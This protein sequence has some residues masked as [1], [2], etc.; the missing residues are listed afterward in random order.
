[1]Q[2]FKFLPLLGALAMAAF[3]AGGAGPAKATQTVYFGQ[4]SPVGCATNLVTPSGKATDEGVVCPNGI[5]F[6]AEGG[7][8]LTAYGYHGTSAFT[9]PSA[10]TLKSGTS[11]ESGLGENQYGPIFSMSGNYATNGVACTDNQSS[12]P[13]PCEIQPGASVAVVS[14]G[15]EY[16]SGVAIVGSVQS[17]EEFS[18]YA[19][20]SLANLLAGTYTFSMTDVMS[21]SSYCDS[22]TGECSFDVPGTDSYAIGVYDVSSVNTPNDVLLT[23]VTVAPAPLIGYGLPVV[24]AVLGLLIGA[25]LWDRSQKRRLPGAIGH[26][27]A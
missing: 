17:P 9:N 21:T 20:T 5:T 15:N 13:N 22:G 27:A 10:L 2:R 19:A 18:I 26:A 16:L 11:G 8:V 6:S 23:A 24:L 12:N 4:Q 1:M 7:T 14:N 25:G 3:L